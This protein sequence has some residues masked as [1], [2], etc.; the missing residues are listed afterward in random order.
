MF[1]LFF[2]IIILKKITVTAKMPSIFCFSKRFK[3]DNKGFGDAVMMNLP[4]AFDII[5]HGLLIAKLH[6]Y[7]FDKSALKLLFS[8]Y[9]NNRWQR[10]KNFGSSE[11]LLQG[12]PQGS[13]LG[14]LLFNIYLNF[15]FYLLS[16]LRFAT[17]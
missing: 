1:Q 17:L 8:L 7:G 9:L 12:V 15:L 13:F 3:K 11:E 6:P 5:S 10:T 4:T 16:L 14:P 2:Q